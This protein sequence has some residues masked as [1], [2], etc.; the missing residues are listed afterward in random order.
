MYDFLLMGPIRVYSKSQ[1]ID[2]YRNIVLSLSK[3]L[4]SNWSLFRKILAIFYKLQLY[5]F[6]KHIP[7]SIDSLLWF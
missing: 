6:S 2:Y 3:A 7:N 1:V 4:L 5:K